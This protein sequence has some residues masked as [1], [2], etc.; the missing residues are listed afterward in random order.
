M[1]SDVRPQNTVTDV[2]NDNPDSSSSVGGIPPEFPAA[3]VPSP[4]TLP[5]SANNTIP[6]K[7][8][9]LPDLDIFGS[10]DHNPSTWSDMHNELF[11]NP[12]DFDAPYDVLTNQSNNNS[13]LNTPLSPSTSIPVSKPVPSPSLPIHY[14]LPEFRTHTPRDSPPPPPVQS[15]SSSSSIPEC[16]QPE[17]Y[18]PS[19]QIPNNNTTSETSPRSDKSTKSSVDLLHDDTQLSGQLP[20]TTPDTSMSQASMSSAVHGSSSNTTHEHHSNNMDK[21]TIDKSWDSL[22][23]FEKAQKVVER[24]STRQQFLTVDRHQIQEFVTATELQDTVTDTY[25][26]IQWAE[27]AIN[28]LQNSILSH[29][30]YIVAKLKAMMPIAEDNLLEVK[31]WWSMIALTENKSKKR[32]R[33]PVSQPRVS[34]PRK[35]RSSSPS[36]T[37]KLNHKDEDECNVRVSTP[38]SNDSTWDTV[39]KPAPAMAPQPPPPPTPSSTN[40]NVDDVEMKIQQV[41]KDAENK[42]AALQHNIHGVCNT[43]NQMYRHMDEVESGT[44]KSRTAIQQELRK[45]EQDIS[46]LHAELRMMKKV[47]KENWQYLS[48]NEKRKTE[49]QLENI[50]KYERT[51]DLTRENLI[52]RLEKQAKQSEEANQR[53]NTAIKKT[54]E[55]VQQLHDKTDLSFQELQDVVRNDR[56][57][58]DHKLDAIKHDITTTT[59]DQIQQ[60]AQQQANKNHEAKL[61][62]ARMKAELEE[63]K[64][65]HQLQL[66][67]QQ[68]EHAEK[69]KQ[70]MEEQQRKEAEYKLSAERA[71]L[72]S[73]QEIENLS[74][75]LDTAQLL[76]KQ[77]MDTMEKRVNELL[78]QQAERSSPPRLPPT[79]STISSPP[80][81]HSSHHTY[82]PVQQ[83]HQ[84][85]ET[86]AS[87]AP[88]PPPPPPSNGTQM[89]VDEPPRNNKA[90]SSNT[91][92]PRLI[93]ENTVQ[94]MMQ[95]LRQEMLTATQQNNGTHQSID[96]NSEKPDGCIPP[97]FGFGQPSSAQNINVMGAA[98][99]YASGCPD[100]PPNMSQQAMLVANPVTCKAKLEEF[101]F[102]PIPEST[103]TQQH[104]AGSNLKF[105]YR[106]RHDVRE[107][108]RQYEELP[109]ERSVN[110]AISKYAQRIKGQVPKWDT[111]VSTFTTWQIG[112]VEYYRDRRIVPQEVAVQF[113]IQEGLD[114]T[115]RTTW[116]GARKPRTFAELFTIL[117]NMVIDPTEGDKVQQAMYEARYSEHNSAM[118][119]NTWFKEQL[120]LVT[121]SLGMAQSTARS[122]WRQGLTQELQDLYQQC[123]LW[124]GNYFTTLNQD[125]C[126]LFLHERTQL[127]VSRKTPGVHAIDTERPK[128]RSRSRESHKHD[129]R[130]EHSRGR[131]PTRKF[132]DRSRSRSHGYDRPRSNGYDRSRSRDK[133]Q[134]HHSNNRD[135]RSNSRDHRSNSRN[136]YDDRNRRS[137]S[138]DRYSR[139]RERSHSGNKYD[140]S[141]SR[142]QD[143]YQSRDKHS[144]DRSRS[145]D[146]RD[147]HSNNN[148][149]YGEG[150]RRSS[151][152][153][154]KSKVLDLIE[155]GTLWGCIQC[156]FGNQWRDSTCQR[157]GRQ[158]CGWQKPQ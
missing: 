131:T 124:F 8:E 96:L 115:I 29:E 75:R 93:D 86:A 79:S 108:I 111:S 45:K 146:R 85:A 77:H 112:V 37:R 89:H 57:S 10:M 157:C 125:M 84:N 105:V 70:A 13:N 20:N 139:S 158:R 152:T 6:S 88:P 4:S 147:N 27:Q 61:A 154:G 21:P 73:K 114:R 2:I 100:L 149:K 142:S 69:L 24:I 120:Y 119:Y 33:T 47:L 97:M 55:S 41:R 30:Q 49:S 48:D 7:P 54:I 151:L 44:N 110:Q 46:S 81:H 58:T 72:A 66:L 31:Q 126:W 83:L 67:L 136:K 62:E 74:T 11:E 150:Y 127:L 18:V 92:G 122:L 40:V 32:A 76:S 107:E 15:S 103:W 19:L 106:I 65:E 51:A 9:L 5:D 116:I 68:R 145:N 63:L 36:N 132:E 14:E 38:R 16:T 94:Q 113:A 102:I 135:H 141:R 153:P 87:G 123:H 34:T 134:S 99:N 28:D 78:Q 22:T 35:H 17:P 101:G 90:S 98:G 71:Q 1:T 25:L 80:P 53:T 42:V 23:P 143:R 39:N 104:Q 50:R 130:H 82:T 43:I 3:D 129:D 156:Q 60:L 128:D 59:Q 26:D 56:S 137:Y 138:N 91:N 144:R 148:R 118:K 117:G 109:D 155:N 121:D 133:Y 64:R 52:A 95:Q 12:P 140:R